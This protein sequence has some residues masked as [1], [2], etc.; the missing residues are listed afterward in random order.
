[1]SDIAL[2]VV[3]TRT[4][5]TI[6]ASDAPAAL[7]LSKY[8]SPLTVWR[9]LRGE[10]VDDTRPPFVQEAAEFG[11]LFEPVI[12]GRYAVQRTALVVVPTHS[13]AYEDWMHATPDGIVIR[14]T[15]PDSVG[16]EEWDKSELPPIADGLLQIKMRSAYL[17]D[18]WLHSVPAETEVQVRVEMAVCGLPWSDVAVLIGGNQMLVHRVE[19]DLALED[20]IL[21]DLRAFWQMVK[22]GR[23]P[24]PDHTAAWRAHV[25]EKMRPTKVTMTADDE[26]REIVDYWLEQRRKRKKYQEEEDAAKN[27]LLLRLAAA[28]A[29]AID[30]GGDRKVTAY[31]VGGRTDYK[32]YANALVDIVT[33]ARLQ[34]PNTAAYKTE[35]K[36]WSLRAPSDDGDE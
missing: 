29:T 19:R 17:R 12:R 8:C 34:A 5:G 2:Y 15:T 33:K 14:S 3:Q 32:G 23:E 18:E 35:G 24:S 28:G 25:S 6:G 21:T 11:H 36:T 10:Y 9:R 7:G 27:D 4:E 26:L 30:L 13:F 16:T 1:M 31:K 20:R 22:D